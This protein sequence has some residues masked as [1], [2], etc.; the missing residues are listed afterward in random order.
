M[1][2]IK[3]IIGRLVAMWVS[4]LVALLGGSAI[5]GGVPA[6]KSAALAAFVSVMGVVQRLA[7]SYYQD[8]RLTPEEA[9][10]AFEFGFRSDAHD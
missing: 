8:G 5:I 9:D 2:Q 10:A 4:A 7:I 6:W 1:T 3:S